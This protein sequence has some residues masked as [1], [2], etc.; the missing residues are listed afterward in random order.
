MHPKPH[1]IGS[2]AEKITDDLG[3]GDSDTLKDMMTDKFKKPKIEKREPL[4]PDGTG[5]G[6]GKDE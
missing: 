6:K 3:V 5:F 4:V 1:F 2:V